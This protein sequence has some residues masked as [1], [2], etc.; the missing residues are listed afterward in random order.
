M[1]IDTLD[2]I[3]R[4][5]KAFGIKIPRNVLFEE[6][7]DWRRRD[8]RVGELH[9]QLCRRLREA[10]RPVPHSSWHR[11]KVCVAE[12]LG[13]ELRKINRESWLFRELGCG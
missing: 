6:S 11:V 3:F 8:V 1:G 12:S 9:E 4:L 2:I 5:E 10:G 13:V 7:W